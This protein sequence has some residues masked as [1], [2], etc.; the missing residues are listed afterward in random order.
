MA[1][2]VLRARIDAGMT[3][4]ATRHLS[5]DQY[6]TWHRPQ[7]GDDAR[8]HRDPTM[9]C[10]LKSLWATTCGASVAP[11][12]LGSACHS[13]IRFERDSCARVSGDFLNSCLDLMAAAVPAIER[14]QR[15]ANTYRWTLQLARRTR[16]ASDGVSGRGDLEGLGSIDSR[17]RA[18]A[19]LSV[20]GG[21]ER[22][23]CRLHAGPAT[24]G[25]FRRS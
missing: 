16:R 13:P 3:R 2:L 22:S 23:G 21:Q 18:G 14:Q 11:V 10:G 7:V 6:W 4:L 1:R 24:T 12:Q 9:V 5:S 25:V 17:Q 20:A 15:S 8:T 19:F